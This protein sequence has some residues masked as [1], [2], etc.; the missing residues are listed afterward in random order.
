VSITMP[1]RGRARP[2]PWPVTY[3]MGVPFL[4]DLKSGVAISGA[5]SSSNASSIEKGRPKCQ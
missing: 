4:E 5:R 1:I 3:S 2:L